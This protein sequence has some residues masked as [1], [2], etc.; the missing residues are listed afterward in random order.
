[1]GIT[2]KYEAS[3]MKS[4]DGETVAFVGPTTLDGPVEV[5]M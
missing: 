1:M 3:A 2:Q 5:M 4:S